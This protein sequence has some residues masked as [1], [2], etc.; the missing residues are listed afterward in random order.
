[1]NNKDIYF[2]VGSRR[3][4][5]QI[6]LNR[7]TKEVSI[8][9]GRGGSS[10]YAK[11]IVDTTENWDNNLMFIP[12]KGLIIVYSDKGTIIRDGQTINVAGI[13]IGDGNSYLI[14]L[15]FVGDEWAVIMEDHIQDTN[16]HVTLEEK[17]FWNDKLNFELIEENLVF[18]RN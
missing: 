14:D 6:G 5:V 17:Q 10:G 16:I 1:M 18:N 4:D 8:R 13:K 9:L 2:G 15:P 11:A 3:K 12:E 7:E